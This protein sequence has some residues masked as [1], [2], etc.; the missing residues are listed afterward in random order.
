M[1]KPAAACVRNQLH[2]LDAAS[3]TTS[4]QRS[5]RSQRNQRNQQ[6]HPPM[7]TISPYHA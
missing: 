2:H 5:Q 4:S 3:T 6:A 1:M 7:Q